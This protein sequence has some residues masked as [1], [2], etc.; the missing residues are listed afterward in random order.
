MDATCTCGHV[1]DEHERGVECTIDDCPCVH[2]EADED[3]EARG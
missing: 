1:Y 3:D 2:F